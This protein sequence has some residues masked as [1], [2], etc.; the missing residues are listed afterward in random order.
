MDLRAGKTAFIT[1]DMLYDFADPGGA[2]FYPQ[3]REILPRVL[4]ALHTAR[5]SGLLVLFAQHYHRRYVFDRELA[6]GRRLNCLEGTGG[7]ALLP[8]LAWDPKTEYVV[9]KRRYNAFTGTDLDLIL[10]E[11]GIANLVLVGTKT[12]CCIRATV[13]GAYHLDYNAVVIRDCVA[14]NSDAVNE[15]HLT[16]IGKYLG[17]VVT[18]DE[19]KQMTATGAVSY[20]HLDV[21][22]RQG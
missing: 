16:D 7:E 5:Q 9:R 18:L 3:N 17:K 6:S 1:I 12:N 19:F 13:E 4:D 14:T 21:Y 15:V 20:T 11:N 8:E 2:V 22:K 10:R